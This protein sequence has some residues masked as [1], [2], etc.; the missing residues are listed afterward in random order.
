[1]ESDYANVLN[2][3]DWG[4]PLRQTH[5]I[6]QHGALRAPTILEWERM[7]GFPDDYTASMGADSVRAK[8]LGDSFHPMKAEWLGRRIVAY[9]ARVPFIAPVRA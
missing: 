7:A 4:T 3:F 9:C 5:L 1:M 8:A 2:G 6:R